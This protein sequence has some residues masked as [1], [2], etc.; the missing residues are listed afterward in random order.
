MTHNDFR[1]V[2]LILTISAVSVIG[3]FAFLVVEFGT[4]VVLV[5]AG[6]FVGLVT[7]GLVS[8]VRRAFRRVP[9]DSSSPVVRRRG[10]WSA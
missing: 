10:G 2:L 3:T 1:A 4:V 7:L 6:L 5:V 8:D 9:L